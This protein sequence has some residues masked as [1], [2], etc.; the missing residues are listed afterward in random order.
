MEIDLPQCGDGG[1]VELV[2]ALPGDGKQRF[3]HGGLVAG[4]GPGGLPFWQDVG[5]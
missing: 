1:E 4:R 3:R 2:H 5:T